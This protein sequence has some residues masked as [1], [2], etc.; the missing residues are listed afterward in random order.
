MATGYRAF[1]VRCSADE[2]FLGPANGL[3]QQ[4]LPLEFPLTRAICGSG[5]DHL[6]PNEGCTC[7][8]Y[9][10]SSMG[11]ASQWTHGE[12]GW[13][14]AEVWA[15]GKVL[16]YDYGYRSERLQIVRFFAPI[17]DTEACQRAAV[18]VV[19]KNG[20]WAAK[21]PVIWDARFACDEHMNEGAYNQMAFG[22]SL[23]SSVP[24]Q[25]FLA[26]LGQKFAASTV[27]IEGTIDIYQRSPEWRESVE[28]QERKRRLD[29]Y[30]ATE[31]QRAQEERARGHY[32]R[33]QAA[34]YREKNLR[35][36]ASRPLI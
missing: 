25:T 10:Y 17:C 12:S 14:M 4:H 13:L 34:K 2:V 5:R 28:A 29:A 22:G 27:S 24:I 3:Q 30:A 19:N 11:G 32:A 31:K 21:R 8:Y 1:R 16:P 33:I 7:G 20:K 35:A 15:H 6:A 26:L 36:A 23:E 9:S 18:L